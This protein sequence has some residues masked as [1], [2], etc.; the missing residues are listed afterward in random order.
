MS[1]RFLL[2]AGL[3]AVL[4]SSEDQASARP[5]RFL[6]PTCP[7]R[8]EAPR[9]PVVVGNRAFEVTTGQEANGGLTQVIYPVADLVVPIPSPPIDNLEPQPEG[10]SKLGKL[11]APAGQTME[12]ELIKLV[13]NSIAP[14]TWSGSGGKGTIEYFPLG[15]CFVVSQTAEIQEEVNDLLTALRR[16]HEV[17]VAVEVRF[18]LTAPDAFDRACKDLKLTLHEEKDASAASQGEWTVAPKG[19]RATAS[20]D[21]KQVYRLLDQLQGDRSSSLTQ[22][23]THTLYNGESRIM[24]CTERDFF[25]TRISI[26]ANGDDVYFAPENRPFTT[27]LRLGLRPVVAA[28]FTS[29]RLEM[30]G[31]WCQRA[32]VTE[33]QPVQMPLKRKEADGDQANEC[34]TMFLA[35]PKFC[36]APLKKIVAIPDGSTFLLHCGS[37]PTEVTHHEWLC[38]PYWLLTGEPLKT[39]DERAFLL[40]VTPH[41]IVNEACERSTRLG[42]VTGVRVH[43]GVGP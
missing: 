25:I 3:V 16:L 31:S 19:K 24:E 23:P 41:I 15:M 42:R 5:R 12:N 38:P 21:S 27:G 20:L 1:P 10:T 34:F 35:K 8:V 43:G 29:V 32:G 17:L 4:C 26:V 9:V 28:D 14:S 13:I 39:F 18:V 37:I 33:Y 7:V 11:S 6:R 2:F 22:T 30:N 40:L 36:T